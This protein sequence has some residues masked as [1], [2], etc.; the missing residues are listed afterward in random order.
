MNAQLMLP[1]PLSFA[2]RC[3][4]SPHS[5][6]RES[7][8]S[9]RYS[10]LSGKVLSNIWNIRKLICVC[11][12]SAGTALSRMPKFA[13]VL[14]MR[15]IT[16]LA[17]SKDDS[18]LEDTFHGNPTY[19]VYNRVHSTLTKLHSP[20]SVCWSSTPDARVLGDGAFGRGLG[21]EE[22]VKVGSSWC[23]SSLI[24]WE[25]RGLALPTM[26]GQQEESLC[27]NLTMLPS[28]PWTSNLQ[29]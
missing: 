11:N 27:Q 8:T 21:V 2:I 18:G 6:F 14:V 9:T 3:K 19:Q 7:V 4:T 23:I 1:S 26:W 28:W 22:V 20:K 24:R 25:T 16:P 29:N 17:C 10:R 13:T 15:P 5:L 12:G